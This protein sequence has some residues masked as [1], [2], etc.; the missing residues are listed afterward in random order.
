M[1]RRILVSVLLIMTV[2]LG[3]WGAI[4]SPA[5][6]QQGGG[7]NLLYDGDFEMGAGAAWPFQD[8]IPEVQ[9][10]PGWRAF[11]VDYPP[12]KARF[13][14]SCGTNYETCSY[15]RRPEFRGVSA[16]EYPTRVHGG[17]LSAKY[18][19][20]SGQH[21]AGFFQQ[22]ANIKPG[23]VLRFSAF[24]QTWSCM[25]DNG[26]WSSCPNG[27]KSKN[28]SPMHTKVGIDPTGGA[29]PWS[30][31]IVWSA[32]VDA[33]DVW[34]QISVDAVAKNSTVTVFT[35]SWAD[36]NDGYFRV[37]NDVYVDDAVLIA[38]GK[39]AVPAATRA[40]SSAPVAPAG[41]P[42]PVPAGGTSYVVQQGDKLSIIAKKY[43]LTV[44]Q[45]QAAN[46]ISDV[47]R[48]KAGQTLVIPPKGAAAAPAATP[49]PGTT[50]AP[51]IKPGTPVPTV[52][53]PAGGT[54]YVVQEGD[55]L[56]LIAKKYGVTVA[57]LQA[58][59]NISDVNR[60]KV[61]QTLVIPGKKP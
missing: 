36:W 5:A 25:P 20:Y 60:I 48:I 1:R 53:V 54:T 50:P 13:P 37:N 34:T 7:G 51:T 49:K 39:G 26:N 24:M 3:T 52:A 23:T 14:V 12:A 16:V 43:G 15:W 42:I 46:N 8:G 10:A 28:P 44:A 30:P 57:Q 11:Y 6:A 40:A 41:T 47:N 58:A 29:D 17:G 45:L 27:D 9:V 59:N 55:K 35:Y 56:S 38:I 32:E 18:F 21:E 61:G 33:Y 22:V 19:S 4:A 2:L 31:N